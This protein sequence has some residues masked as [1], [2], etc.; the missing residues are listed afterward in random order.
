MNSLN[1]QSYSPVHSPIPDPTDN[2][3]TT[4][5]QRLTSH[6]DHLSTPGRSPPSESQSPIPVHSPTSV[7]SDDHHQDQTAIPQECTTT[8]N[9]K[10]EQF[11]KIHNKLIKEPKTNITGNPEKILH[12]NKYEE[13]DM[14]SE[15]L[16]DEENT[17]NIHS[18]FGETEPNDSLPYPCD[19]CDEGFPSMKEYMN[20]VRAKHNGEPVCKICDKTFKDLKIMRNH[21][22]KHHFAK[23]GSADLECNTCGKCFKIKEQLKFHCNFV[24]KIEE[25]P[26]CNLCGKRCQNK[27]KLW[28]HVRECLMKDPEVV[29]QERLYFDAVE[30]KRQELHQLQANASGNLNM[31]KDLTQNDSYL[32]EQESNDRYLPEQ[33]YNDRYLPKPE[34]KDNIKTEIDRMEH[35]VK[36]ETEP[37][38]SEMIH[39]AKKPRKKYVYPVESKICPICAKEVKYLNQHIE[40]LHTETDKIHICN[41]CGKVCGKLRQLRDHLDTT[42]K[43]EPS[44]CDICS[45]VF[46]NARSLR[47]HKKKV[48]EGIGEVNCPSCNKVFE[49]K[50]KL[51]NHEKAVHLI[52]NSMCQAC[53]KTYKNRSLLTKHLRVYHIEL[54]TALQK[55][56]YFDE[57]Q[58]T[59]EQ[60]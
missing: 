28:R 17:Y 26:L 48:H 23:T 37:D 51:Y 3:T 7:H 44:L 36:I 31:N 50:A 34:D 43:N 42:H 9:T 6:E 39:G 32:L 30:N 45:K 13:S 49:S 41:Q 22:R 15:N 27:L 52:Q 29:A 19:R 14:S 60:S 20:H 40:S 10:T 18:V 56:K 24:H 38:I 16:S 58:Q 25:V 47:N 11:S 12:V 46:K 59:I 53:G 33:E 2:L 4:N 55:K 21:K 54:Y 35:V 1:N 57:R 5:E 8:S